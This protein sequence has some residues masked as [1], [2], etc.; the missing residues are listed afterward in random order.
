MANDFDLTPVS[1]NP[2]GF[3]DR[4]SDWSKDAQRIDTEPAG[5]RPHS[6]LLAKRTEHSR[7]AT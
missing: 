5:R 1:Y 4:L 3:V 6:R 2:F 7:H